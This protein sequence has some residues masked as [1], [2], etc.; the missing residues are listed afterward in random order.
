MVHY[1]N[2]STKRWTSVDEEGT[3]TGTPIL[4]ITPDNG[5]SR[6]H[7]WNFSTGAAGTIQNGPVNN[8]LVGSV[9]P[10]TGW[11]I[12]F[13]TDINVVFN[14]QPAVLPA[15]TVDLRDIDTS[16]QNKTFYIYAL[17]RDGV[18]Q[19][20]VTT[21][22]RLE[23]AYQLWVAT[24][25]TNASQILTIDR[26][27]VLAMNGHRVSEVKRGNSIPATSGLVNEEGQIPWFYQSEILP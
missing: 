3:S 9:Y 21:Q 20:E 1:A 8:A 26:Y 2:R 18:A 4:C 13:K 24:V 11:I 22:K 14:G 12:F 23:S 27:N 7:P 5:I 17:M 6:A 16:P 10:E 25:K 15:G 19:Y